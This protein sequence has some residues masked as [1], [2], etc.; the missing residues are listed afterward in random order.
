MKKL[1]VAVVRMSVRLGAS[2]WA[3]PIKV[4]IVINRPAGLHL[5]AVHA[6]GTQ[7]IPL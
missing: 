4:G 1:I 7:D 5:R 3:Q 6:K 2:G